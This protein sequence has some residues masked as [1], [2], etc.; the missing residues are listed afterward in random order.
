MVEVFAGVALEGHDD[1][2]H[3]AGGALHDVLPTLF[4]GG[5]RDGGGGGL[6]LF[7]HEEGGGVEGAAVEDL[8]A[9]QME[10]H[11]VSVLSEVNK[12]PDLSGV[13]LGFLRGGLMPALAVEQH[14][15]RAGGFVLVLVEGDGAGLDG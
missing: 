8:E 11:G 5:R 7:V 14:D 6:K 9:H 13:E 1:A 4:V 12:L 3:D 10:M 15:H 2:R